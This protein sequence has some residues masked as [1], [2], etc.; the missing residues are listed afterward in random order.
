MAQGARIK[1]QL[2]GKTQATPKQHAR[3]TALGRATSERVQF[4][5]CPTHGRDV[6]NSF[7]LQAFASFPF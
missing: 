4:R 6:G 1:N 2:G 3:L 7:L 5:L